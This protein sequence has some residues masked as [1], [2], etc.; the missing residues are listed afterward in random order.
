MLVSFRQGP[1]F[2][3]YR[4]ATD[5]AG[6]GS[7]LFDDPAF[8]DVEAAMM[9]PRA[10]PMGHISAMAPTKKTGTIICLDANYTSY[11]PADGE[12]PKAASVRVTVPGDDGQVRSIGE[13]P[14]ETDGSFMA[15]VPIDVPL[16][17]EALDAKGQILRQTPPV[18]WVRAGENRSCIGCHEPHGRS[19]RNHRPLAP[20]RPTPCLPDTQGRT[21][22]LSHAP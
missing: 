8:D 19:P 18:V 13:V 7:P 22:Q 14:L 17:F 5:T 9:V 10:R 4:L 20:R 21:T 11:S 16:G 6:L 2:A 15:T 12:V 3:I 1:S